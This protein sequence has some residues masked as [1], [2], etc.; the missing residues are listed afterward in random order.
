M[1]T[2]YIGRGGRRNVPRM[3][4]NQ[5]QDQSTD[6]NLADVI[7]ERVARDEAALPDDQDQ[8]QNTTGWSRQREGDAAPKEQPA[9]K[10][11]RKQEQ[12]QDG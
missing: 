8:V 6:S 1:S 10:A 4:E 12:Q 9:K 3:S 11:P 5:K 2:G 7:T